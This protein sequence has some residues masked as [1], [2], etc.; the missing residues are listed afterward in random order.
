M[1]MTVDIETRQSR[2]EAILG[3]ALGDRAYSLANMGNIALQDMGLDS[4]ATINLLF[5]LEEDLGI[6]FPDS[7][8]DKK[9]FCTGATI[10][11]AVLEITGEG[12]EPCQM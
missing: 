8:L 9:Y 1:D 3:E 11:A 4:V 6:T 7:Y 2:L 10:N 12:F 5:R